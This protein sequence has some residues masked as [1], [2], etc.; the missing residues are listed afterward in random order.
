MVKVTDMNTIEM[1]A[2][3]GDQVLTVGKCSSAQA[4]I[5]VKKEHAAWEDGKLLLPLDPE[6]LQ[7][8]VNNPDGPLDDANVSKKE[9]E[10]RMAWL[11]SLLSAQAG[12]RASKAR[13]NIPEIVGHALLLNFP[14][15]VVVPNKPTAPPPP[16]EPGAW[17]DAGSVDKAGEDPRLQDLWPSEPQIGTRSTGE[18]NEAE[19]DEEE[20]PTLADIWA[21]EEPGGHPGRYGY[22]SSLKAPVATARPEPLPAEW[23]KR[24]L[25]DDG[26]VGVVMAPFT[27][28]KGQR[29]AILGENKRCWNLAPSKG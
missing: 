23:L 1:I 27:K 17:F 7:V 13:S 10:R 3:V 26:G 8:A 25:H 16:G 2:R 11:R 28:A 24:H 19:A 21:A 14:R 6:L 4:R 22:Q 20:P 29:I 5:L 15:E 18:D 12:S 9:K